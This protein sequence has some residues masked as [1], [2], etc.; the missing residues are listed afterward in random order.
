[1]HKHYACKLFKLASVKFNLLIDLRICTG[2][3]V[4][5]RISTYSYWRFGFQ[6]GSPLDRSIV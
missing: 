5:V 6:M 4:F 2:L 1:M 3:Y